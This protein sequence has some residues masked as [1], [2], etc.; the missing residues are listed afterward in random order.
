[1]CAFAKLFVQTM[2]HF[3]LNTEFIPI[4]NPT[5]SSQALLHKI[6]N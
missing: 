5:F 4:L 1:M 6:K 3:N 2:K